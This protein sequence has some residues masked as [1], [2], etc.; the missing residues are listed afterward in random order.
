MVVGDDEY[1]DHA[2]PIHE[3]DVRREA[4]DGE[5]ANQKIVR[6]ARYDSANLRPAGDWLERNAHG[7]E[8]LDAQ[9][10]PLTVVPNRHVFDLV[11]HRRIIGMYSMLPNLP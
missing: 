11:A 3:G 5:S 10:L 4:R 9:T 6:H 1:S 2:I 7:I 8:E